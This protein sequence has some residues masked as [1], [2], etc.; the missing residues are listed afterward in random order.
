MYGL[1]YTHLM[2]YLLCVPGEAMMSLIIGAL[3][4]HEHA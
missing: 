2:R 3:R 1:S 4:M